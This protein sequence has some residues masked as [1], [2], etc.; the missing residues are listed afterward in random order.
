[1]TDSF[2]IRAGIFAVMFLAS[3]KIRT[4]YKSRFAWLFFAFPIMGMVLAYSVALPQSSAVDEIASRGG[5]VTVV[6][7]VH[8]VT[9]TTTGMQRL[10]IFTESITA[11]GEVYYERLKIRAATPAD[12]DELIITPGSRVSFVGTLHKLQPPRN[13]GGFNELHHLGARGYDYTMRIVYHSVIGRGTTFLSA[14]RGFRDNITAIYYQ[15]LPYDKAGII[16]AMVTGD[17]SGLTDYVRELYRDSG[18]YHV[19]V[20]SGMHISIMGLFADRLLR[21]FVSTKAAAFATLGFLCVFAIFTGASTSTVR[22]VLMIAILLFSKFF[23]KEPDLV[24]SASLAGLIMLFYEPRWVFDVGFQYS[25]SAVLGLGFFLNPIV[26]NFKKKTEIEKG[27]LLWFMEL[28]AASLIVFVS[29]I[30]VQIYHFNH[31]LPYQ[32]FVN[33]VILPLLS[34]IIVPGFIMGLLGLIFSPAGGLLSGLIYFL[35]AFYENVSLFVI[36][37]P[38]SRILRATPHYLFAISFLGALVG[39]WYLSA[40][41]AKVKIKV[42]FAITAFSIW[43]LVFGIYSLLPRVPIM[44]KLDV[45]QGDA[46]VIERYGEVFIIDAGGWHSS[47]QPIREVGRNTGARVIIPYLERRGISRI[48]GVFVS[49]LHLDHAFGAVELLE[50]MEVARLYLPILTD[51]SYL[52]Y[53]MLINT[54]M[55]NDV[56]VV[57]L[58]AGDFFESPEGISFLV[59]SPSENVI[60]ENTN[61]ASLV[62]YVDMGQ[63]VMFTGDIG[64]PT[65]E[66]LIRHFSHLD[67]DILK[68][69]HHGSRFSTGDAFLDA[70]MPNVAIAGVGMHNVFGH[71][72]PTVTSRLYDRG[73]LFYSTHT[74]GAITI[75]LNDNRIT[76]MLGGS[77]P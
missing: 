44:I 42:K 20:I 48:D 36:G 60:Y 17:R 3:V 1:M 25:F 14:L 50:F 13:P 4:M 22:A 74:H 7:L 29:T 57:Y 33:M 49:H 77:S 51:R 31:I 67:I 46:V 58:R 69:A 26:W 53:Q 8:D 68:L 6:G 28:F 34:F 70:T 12:R 30:P 24:S 72:H 52:V 18:I 38:F 19:L 66:R 21:R 2:L 59:L 27:P 9:F 11:G 62:L 56:E 39:L 76:T 75:N 37:L 23:Q 32:I 61:E 47:D 71:P 63:R 10:T 40:S 73:V 54:A 65:E 35:L 45:G 15:W 5:P 64:L 55:E 16:S 41:D 43:I